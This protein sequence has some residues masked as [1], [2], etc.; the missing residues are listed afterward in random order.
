MHNLTA[1]YLYFGATARMSGPVDMCGKQPHTLA[2]RVAVNGQLAAP[3]GPSN[4]FEAYEIYRFCV[5]Y[6]TFPAWAAPG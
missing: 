4:F 1:I 3:G 2:S 6:V 5:K